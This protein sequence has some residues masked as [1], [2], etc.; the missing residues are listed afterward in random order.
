MLTPIITHHNCQR[1]KTMLSIYGYGDVTPESRNSEARVRRHLISN[2]QI[3]TKF[4]LKRLSETRFRNNEYAGINERVTQRLTHVFMVT[5]NNRGMNYCTW[6]SISDPHK[7]SSG[8]D[9][10]SGDR[11][12]TLQALQ[13]SCYQASRH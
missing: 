6:C 3:C 4:P 7:A 11:I 10:E 2:G 1:H 5:A 12:Q 8:R 13:D 9:T